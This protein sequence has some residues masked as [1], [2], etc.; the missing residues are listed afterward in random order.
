MLNKHVHLTK[1]WTPTTAVTQGP[2]DRLKARHEQRPDKRIEGLVERLE[3]ELRKEILPAPRKGS[4]LQL[5]SGCDIL[6]ILGS[7]LPTLHWDQS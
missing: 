6:V 7:R 5:F 2:T 3:T 4:A 1:E